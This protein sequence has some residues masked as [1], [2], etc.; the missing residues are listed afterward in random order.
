MDT[1]AQ[2]EYHWGEKLDFMFDKTLIKFMM[3]HPESEFKH[4]SLSYYLSLPYPIDVY[5]EEQGFTVMIPD[6]PGCMSQGATMDEAMLNLDRAKH[7]WLE[8]VYASDK[9]SIPLPSK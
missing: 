5:P 4:D 3:L 7:L 8:T 9:N 2:I 6:L 1:L